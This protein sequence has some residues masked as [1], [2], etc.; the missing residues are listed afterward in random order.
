MPRRLALGLVAFAV[1][2]L[3]VRWAWILGV[4]PEVPDVGD[5]S[6]YHLLAAGIADGEGYVR[7]FDRVL[8][9]LHRPTAEYPPLHPAVLSAAAF[10]GV[11][12]VTGMRLWLALF[13]AASVSL[14]GLL[15]WR[16]SGRGLAALVAAAVAAVHPL[17]FQADATLMPET[18]AALL[19][20]A[21]VLLAVEVARQPS[22]RRSIVLGAACGLAALT[23]AEAVVLLVAVAVPA[24]VAGARR[25]Q[26]AAITVAAATL[27]VAPW[28]ARNL[29]RFDRV[30]PISTNAGSVADGA[31]CDATYG[32]PLLGYWQFSPSCFEGF[33]QDE[34][35]A[36]DEA[37]VAST[38]RRAGIR[39]ALDHA[40]DWPA[41]AAARLGRTLAVF[42]PG[43]LADL[44]AL[45]GRRQGADLAGFALVWASV[46]LA[47]LGSRALRRE[48]RRRW[49]VP[50]AAVAAI[51]ASTALTYGNPRFL[52]LA[53]PALV[54]LAGCGAASLVARR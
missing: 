18:L 39:Y 22:A 27:V 42:R 25:W 46:P 7:P 41:V 35:A 51:W 19:G 36:R 38:H 16:L 32:G 34:L 28:L 52:A 49:W 1:L 12:G 11:D 10:A 40:G 8:F 24:A 45:E 14:T 26:A 30:V 54:A 9:G 48:Q 33:Q 4:E 3:V 5:A 50:A 47:A 13:G 29:A 37:A 6:A 43:Q 53:Q 20:G 2:G 31:N 15:A 21:V 23:R 44:G 17:W